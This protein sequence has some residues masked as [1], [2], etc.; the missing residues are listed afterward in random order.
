MGLPLSARMGSL[1]GIHQTGRAGTARERMWRMSDPTPGTSGNKYH[2]TIY[3]LK[4]H[5]HHR[6]HL[7]VDVYCVLSAFIVTSPG[8]QHAAKKLLCAGLR[9]KAS[10]LQD[11][12]EA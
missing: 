3:G 10:R 8:L 6:S 1:E 2:R 5:G 7:V 11:L 12:R 9:G 4:S